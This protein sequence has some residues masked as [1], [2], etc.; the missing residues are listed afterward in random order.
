MLLQINSLSLSASFTCEEFLEFTSELFAGE[1][2]KG[3]I[4]TMVDNRQDVGDSESCD[5]VTVLLRICLDGGSVTEESGE[6]ER[7]V[8]EDEGEG[9]EQTHAGQTIQT[10][11]GRI[12]SFRNVSRLRLFVAW[13]RMDDVGFLRC[14][15]L[16]WVSGISWFDLILCQSLTLLLLL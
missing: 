13:V 6:H 5:D 16:M 4:D 2:V 15:A 9:Q 3:T 14:F 7:C 12:L 10:V 1:T 11:R 8:E